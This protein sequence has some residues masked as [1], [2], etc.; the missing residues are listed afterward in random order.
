MHLCLCLPLFVV[1]EPFCAVFN[2][3]HLE[4]VSIFDQPIFLLLTWSEIQIII[5]ALKLYEQELAAA[6]AMPAVSAGTEESPLQVETVTGLLNRAQTAIANR[7][8]K[9]D[10]Q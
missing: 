4:I 9:K 6:S 3:A 8:H 7:E 2:F 5:D 10:V 1:L